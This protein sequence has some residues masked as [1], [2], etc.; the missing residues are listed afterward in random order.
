[1]LLLLPLLLLLRFIL[2]SLSDEI[3]LQIAGEPAFLRTIEPIEFVL[4]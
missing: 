2:A 1:L 4:T 3:T